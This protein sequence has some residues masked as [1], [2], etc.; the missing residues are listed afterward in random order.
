MTDQNTPKMSSPWFRASN[1]A[2]TMVSIYRPD[3]M[4]DRPLRAGERKLGNFIL[5]D[6]Q[7]PPVWSVDQK[8]RF[9][10]SIWQ[11]LPLGAYIVNRVSGI[12]SPYDNLL[13]D[14]QQ[15]ITAILDYV[16]DEFAVLGYRWS[17]LNP[18]DRR[19]FGLIPMSYMETSLED[20]N[21]LREVYDR[22]AYGGTPHEPKAV[23]S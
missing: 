18:I 19:Q 8:I 10:E 17:E 3:A 20:M 23:I 7:R 2:G 5:P 6:F 13:L 1:T 11:R 4:W 12:D 9:I 16:A 15:R 22:L 21:L 14:G